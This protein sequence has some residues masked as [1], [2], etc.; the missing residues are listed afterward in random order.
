MHAGDRGTGMVKVSKI[1][2]GWLIISDGKAYR[3]QREWIY[4]LWCWVL[5]SPLP[6]RRH[7]ILVTADSKTEMYRKLEVYFAPS[8]TLYG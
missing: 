5:R 7:D 3:V 4:G 1:E 2:K 6:H 8:L